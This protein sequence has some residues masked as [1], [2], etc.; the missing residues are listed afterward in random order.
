MY[1]A[2]QGVTNIYECEY[3]AIFGRAT[4]NDNYVTS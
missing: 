2:K 4:S 1:M 3:N